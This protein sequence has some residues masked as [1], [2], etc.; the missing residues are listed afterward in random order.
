VSI[1]V[2]RAEDKPDRNE[3]HGFRTKIVERVEKMAKTPSAQ[4]EG[5]FGRKSTLVSCAERVIV[6][7]GQE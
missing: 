3:P 6:V 2:A 5:R 7:D 4:G 1:P